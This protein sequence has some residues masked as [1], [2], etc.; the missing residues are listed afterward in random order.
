MKIECLNHTPYGDIICKH[1]VRNLPTILPGRNTDVINILTDLIIGSKQLRYGPLPSPERLVNI[2]NVIRDAVA[3]DLPIPV[4]VPWGGR[5][6]RAGS[7]LDVAEISGIQRIME[8]NETV[9]QFHKPGMFVRLRIEDVNANWLYRDEPNAAEEIDVYSS[10]MFNLVDEMDKSQKISPIKETWLIKN[11]DLYFN[12]A[13]QL[14]EMILDYLIVTENMPEQYWH[15]TPGF[16]VLQ[17]EGWQGLIPKE[18]REYYYARY[19]G[20]D[21]SITLPEAMKKLADY[22]A[23]SKTRHEMNA[24]GKPQTSVDGFIQANFAHPVPGAPEGLF[25]TTIYWRTIPYSDGRTQIAP[26]R[27]KGY[28]LI[29]KEA[30]TT[31]IMSWNDP[32][33]DEL[34]PATVIITG[35]N[36]MKIKVQADYL[37]QD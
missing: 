31:K 18:Q 10:A 13:I 15:T 2:R 28:L 34:E 30:V 3:K 33:I 14:S 32:K 27:A 11:S 1:F 7:S 29:S 20:L 24:T 35:D 36:N 37:T 23:G 25:S 26:W 21:P 19:R 12:R 9:K 8:V 4:L 6:A 17:I 22:F 5:K 16:K